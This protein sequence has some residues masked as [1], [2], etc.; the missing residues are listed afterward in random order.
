MLEKLRELSLRYESLE[1]QL[2]D[3][4][5]YGDAGRLAAVNRE[6]RELQPVVDVYRAY[7]AAERRRGPSSMTRISGSWPR[8]SW[9]R[10]RRRPSASTGS[11]PSCSCPKTPTTAAT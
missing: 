10:P 11:S 5:V 8:R 6:L 4:A 9:R 3:P 2:T 7:L 1:T